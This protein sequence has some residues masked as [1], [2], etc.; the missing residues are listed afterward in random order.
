MITKVMHILDF[1]AALADVGC[2][3]HDCFLEA[4]LRAREVESKGFVCAVE[5]EVDAEDGVVIGFGVADRRGCVQDYTVG[6]VVLG[7]V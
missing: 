6:R 7:Y 5:I 3:G 1:G 4:E 2:P